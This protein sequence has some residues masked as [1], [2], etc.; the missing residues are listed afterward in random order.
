MFECPICKKDFKTLKDYAA[1]IN[2]EQK[3]SEA[4]NA[5]RIKK[6]REQER[7]TKEAQIKECYANLKNLIKEYNQMEGVGVA[8]RYECTLS[9]LKDMEK[10]YQ[11]VAEML[12]KALNPFV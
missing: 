8:G 1:H 11:D 12:R 7:M 4:E 5:E 2:S 10:E 9:I 3:K 6:E